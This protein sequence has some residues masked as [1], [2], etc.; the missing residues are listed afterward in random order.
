M[1]PVKNLRFFYTLNHKPDKYGGFS[2]Y[3]CM[4]VDKYVIVQMITQVDNVQ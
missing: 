3:T 1:F 2:Y 4:C